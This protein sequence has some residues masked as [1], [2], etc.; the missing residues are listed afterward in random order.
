MSESSEGESLADSAGTFDAAEASSGRLP[1]P[2]A[3]EPAE[4][5]AA[6]PAEV[7]AS[8]DIQLIA[9]FLSGDGQAFDSLFEKYHAFVYRLAFGM[10]GDEERANDVVQEAFVRVFGA[11]HTYRGQSS[12][13][14]WLR[15]VTINVC[16]DILRR[17][18]RREQVE[19][20]ASEREDCPLPVGQDPEKTAV[21]SERERVLY[22]CIAQLH[23]SQQPVVVCYDLLQWSYE[24]ISEA[25]GWPVGTVKSRHF[26]AHQ[27][28]RRKLEPHRE[29]FES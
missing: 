21:R 18:K 2:P 15:R 20:A 27:A 23:P 24:E 25:L 14:T 22:A 9:R 5:P 26:R 19:S 17:E 6:Q 7:T 1:E 29:L 12:F 3:Q 4:Q 16:L 10:T 8:V 28:L 11:L 13:A